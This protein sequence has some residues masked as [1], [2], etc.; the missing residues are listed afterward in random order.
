MEEKSRENPLLKRLAATRNENELEGTPGRPLISRQVYG[1]L[2]VSR[3]VK[4][5]LGSFDVAC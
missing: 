4:L 1:M 2:A 3:Q 5:R